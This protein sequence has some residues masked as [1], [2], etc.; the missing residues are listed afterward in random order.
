M[1]ISYVTYIT[2]CVIVILAYGDHMT[3][4]GRGGSTEIEMVVLYLYTRP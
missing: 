1:V 2:T 4:V 3:L